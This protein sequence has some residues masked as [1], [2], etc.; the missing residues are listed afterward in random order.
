MQSGSELA[1]RLRQTESDYDTDIVS[2]AASNHG[3]QL[4]CKEHLH[5]LRSEESFT[6]ACRKPSYASG[7]AH[8]TW[9]PL[10]PVLSTSL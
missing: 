6:V 1:I 4:Y 2:P 7:N 10:A 8:D 3:S 5:S 9:L